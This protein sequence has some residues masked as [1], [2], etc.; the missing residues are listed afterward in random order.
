[1]KNQDGIL[2]T[3]YEKPAQYFNV[4]YDITEVYIYRNT[5]TDSNLKLARRHQNMNAERSDE[6]L[7]Y[8]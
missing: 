1:M 6:K 5:D 7:P 2:Y 4:G 8:K 3:V